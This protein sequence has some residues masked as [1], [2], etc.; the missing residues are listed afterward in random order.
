M[1]ITAK[2][3]ISAEGLTKRY[4]STEAL[5][6]LSFQVPEGEVFGF[7]GAN[8]AGKT[9][10]LRILA[11]LSR[12]DAGWAKVDGVDVL[13]DVPSLHGVIGYMPD[14]FGVYDTMT[15]AEYLAFYASCYRVPKHL[16]DRVADDLLELVA[17]T[18]R[19]DAQVD[20]L[21]RGMKQRLCLARAL[22]HDPKVLL[23]DEPAS[24]LDPRARTE[25]RELVSVLREMGKTIVLSSHILPE[26]AEM[27]SSYGVIHDGRM[28][29]SGPADAI[30]AAVGPLHARARVQGDIEEAER[31][32]S[33]IDGVLTVQRSGVGVGVLDI[34]YVGAG[35]ET[36]RENASNDAAALL[37]ALVVAGIQVVDFRTDE[38]GLEQLF[39]NL[40]APVTEAQLTASLA[41]EQGP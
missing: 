36:G 22:V 14:F 30:L 2:P 35:I 20:S 3:M 21:S 28:V 1:P 19:R 7:I 5:S 27:C 39:L 6:G 15:A 11:G 38:G 31:L 24:G 34:E 8:G 33:V 10:T 9:T 17:L 26:L 37:R 32:A 41:A 13:G 29:A 40:T 4:G 23:L 25:M 16:V 12:P 18:G